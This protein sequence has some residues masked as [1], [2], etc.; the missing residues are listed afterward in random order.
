MSD[1][2]SSGSLT[3]NEQDEATAKFFETHFKFGKTMSLNDDTV[4]ALLSEKKSGR[5]TD[6]S[7]K[8]YTTRINELRANLR[9]YT[10]PDM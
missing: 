5:I 1:F 4:L 6:A 3:E 2:P 9:V 10:D 7:I 8:R